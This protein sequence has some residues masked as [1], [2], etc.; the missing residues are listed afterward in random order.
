MEIEF[1]KL[2]N[3]SYKPRIH[4]NGFI[5]LDITENIRLHVWPKENLIKDNIRLP[6]HDHT[7]GFDSFVMNG[8]IG[9]KIFDITKD[10]N[11]TY[12][13]YTVMPYVAIKKEGI[14]E[15]SDG[16]YSLHETKQFWTNAGES[17][18]MDPFVFHESQL[19]Q[20]AEIAVTA[21]KILPFDKN[22]S[23]RVLCPINETPI[24]SFQRDSIDQDTLWN[25]IEK[26]LSESIYKKLPDGW[27]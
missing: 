19:K 24:Q 8:S 21:I 16:C 9:N 1:E 13:L 23:A 26:G 15:K 10:Q 6:M 2:K 4:P 22:M 5:Q 3:G 27:L 25:Y 14:L 7:F 17:Y 18:H 12:N 20:D 11:G